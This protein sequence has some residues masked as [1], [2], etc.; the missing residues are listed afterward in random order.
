MDFFVVLECPGYRVG[1]R[2]RC[3]ARVGIQHRVTKED[4]MKCFKDTKANH[5]N[6]WIDNFMVQEHDGTV[7]E[8]GWCKQKGCI[9]VRSSNC[10][11]GIIQDGS[12]ERLIIINH[13]R[14]IKTIKIMS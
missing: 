8:W 10:V 12:C 2:R 9:V 1:R 5:G 6:T 13:M 7:N 3:K 4:A 14:K 11:I